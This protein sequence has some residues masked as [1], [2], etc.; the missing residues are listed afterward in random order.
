MGHVDIYDI[1]MCV[2]IYIY[3]E[4]ISSICLYVY[5][6]AYIPIICRL[7]PNDIPIN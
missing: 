5:I 2:Y 4:A 7:Y 1:Y 3:S 6:P